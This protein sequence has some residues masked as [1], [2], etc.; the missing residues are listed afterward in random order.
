MNTLH[1]KISGL[2]STRKYYQLG[3]ESLLNPKEGD[4][5]EG[6]S[7][8]SL[9]DSPLQGR[10]LPHR[11]QFLILTISL[12]FFVFLSIALAG[13]YAL[14]RTSDR[15]CGIQTGVFSPANEAVEYLEMEFDNAFA[16][17]TIYRGPPTPDLE[18]AWEDL[19]YYGGV[20]ITDDQ[21]PLLNRTPDLG[22]G[23]RLKPV[24]DE[25]GGYHALIEVF[26]QL[27]CLNLIRQYTWKDWYFRHPDVVRTPPDVRTD[28]ITA[29]MHVDHCIEALRISLMCHGDTTPYMV[30]NDP[31]APNNMRAD[32]SPHHKCRNFDSIKEWVKEN[33]LAPP[34]P[35]NWEGR[36]DGKQW[37]HGKL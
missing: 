31:T 24:G 17:D 23:R 35:T 12:L 11:R 20:R 7:E 26:H 2:F 36:K 10:L 30:L 5:N 15:D 13:A 19:W 34:P 4:Y 27:H 6:E 21:L 29:R 33:Q 1:A 18:R 22:N 28:E 37:E 14:K 32:F 8:R 9:E 16:H 25:K 3:T